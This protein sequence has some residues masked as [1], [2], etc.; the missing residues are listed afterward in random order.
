M[1]A[2]IRPGVQLRPTSTRGAIPVPVLVQDSRTSNTN[3]TPVITTVTPD[4]TAHIKG[5]WTELIAS[6]TGDADF[7]MFATGYAVSS[8][9]NTSGMM[10]DVALGAAG[11]E[12]IIASNVTSGGYGI[13]PFLSSGSGRNI[14]LPL[15]IP[16]GSRVAVRVQFERASGSNFQFSTQLLRWPTEFGLSSPAKLDTIGDTPAST[17]GVALSTTSNTAVQVTASAPNTYQGF[18]VCL[19][20]NTGS[21]GTTYGDTVEIGIGASGA[22][23]WQPVGQQWAFY[24]T[25]QIRSMVGSHEALLVPIH[26]PKG[27][28]IAARGRGNN[29]SANAP[30]VVLL[31]VPYA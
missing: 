12:A 8:N 30:R 31:G 15:R 20:S 26:C 4:A 25:E 3:P 29:Q 1:R 28:R 17:T 6:T 9:G 13:D 5:A 27:A 7:I 2:L 14:T 22:E 18:V 11:S 16:K 10:F 21:Q 24:G 19:L 23:R